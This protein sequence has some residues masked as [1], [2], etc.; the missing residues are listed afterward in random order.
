MLTARDS[1]IDRVVGFEVGA[2][3]YVAKPFSV[4]ELMLRVRAILRRVG[5]AGDADNH[6]LRFGELSVDQEA[7]TVRVG[8]SEVDLTAL[9]FR[10]LFRLLERK[11]KVQTRDVLL[12]HV[13]ALMPTS[14]HEPWTPMSNGCVKNWQM[15]ATISKPCGVWVTV[16]VRRQKRREP[17]WHPRAFVRGIQHCPAAGWFGAW[18]RA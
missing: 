6:E 2:D 15:L 17:S 12:Q 18:A 7:H 13:G 1:E 5:G 11:G 8:E 3:D 10:L 16:G 4:R 9:E 14:P